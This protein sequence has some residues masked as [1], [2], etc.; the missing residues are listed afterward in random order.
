MTAIGNRALNRIDEETPERLMP[1]Y[2]AV[3]QTPRCRCMK[4]VSRRS[5]SGVPSYT[6]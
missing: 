6:I 5:A 4:V 3:A 1:G 2:R